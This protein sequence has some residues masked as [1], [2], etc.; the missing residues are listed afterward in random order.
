[1]AKIFS[2]F[3]FLLERITWLTV[4]D[5][6]LVTTVFYIILRVL[7]STQ[8][9]VLLRGVLLLIMIFGLFTTIFNLPAF[10]WLI[11]ISLP[12]LLFA[13]PVIFAPEIRRGLE[14]IGRVQIGSVFL[15]RPPLS[16]EV[17]ERL[18]N[19]VLS[20]C[21]HLAEHRY[22]AIIVLQQ[23][24]DLREY[25]SSGVLIDATC[26]TEL[27]LQVFYPNTPLHDGAVVIVN[28]RLKAAGC[29]LPLSNDPGLNRSPERTSGLRHRAAVGISEVSDAIA[30]VVS[31]ETGAISL[32]H[33]GHINRRVGI[34]KL[35]DLLLSFYAQSVLIPS[36]MNL[37]SRIK[38]GLESHQHKEAK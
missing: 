17:V 3:L 36:T 19:T 20:A 4:L 25:I 5:V 32:A 24:D 27:L 21:E 12:A 38:Q 9:V 6:I 23:N 10:S 11:G 34:E 15:F 7:R 31:E 28:D 29:V 35:K 30:L 2:D 37:S 14:R 22:G 1:M 16:V 18:I 26:T 33:D 8:A 13:I